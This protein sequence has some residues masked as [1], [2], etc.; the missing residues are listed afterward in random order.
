MEAHN[1]EL[2]LYKRLNAQVLGASMDDPVT[3]R[4][5]ARSLDLDFPIISNVLPWMGMQY[6]AFSHTKPFLQD[7]SPN[8][9]GRRTVIIDKN[10]I[11]RYIRD[12]HLDVKDVLSNLLK[13]EKEFREKK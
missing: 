2:Y 9:F 13:I 11:V 5:F 4:Y 10:G 7:G 1:R 6:G 12:G 8:W 3:N